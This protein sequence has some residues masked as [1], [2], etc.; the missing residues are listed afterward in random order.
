MVFRRLLVLVLAALAVGVTACGDGDRATQVAAGGEPAA[1]TSTS[2]SIDAGSVPPAVV[3]TSTPPVVA[4]STST[5]APVA[6]DE[7]SAP[8]PVDGLEAGQL[9][10]VLEAPVSGSVRS[11][12]GPTV[13]QVTLPDG[14]HV[15]RVRVPG[16]FT[17]RSA[18]IAVTV[19]GRQVGEAVLAPDLQSITAVTTD[20]RGLTAGRPVSYQWEGGPS[21]PAG[22]LAVVR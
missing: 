15:W 21:V 19:G 8:S 1:S 2:T 7:G 17:V 16:P 5:T 20:G 22:T 11:A 6:P 9:K 13:D 10:A 18:R 3:T 12:A 4:T 14:T